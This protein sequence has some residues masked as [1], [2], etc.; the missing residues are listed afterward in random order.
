MAMDFDTL[1]VI[2]VGV[3][4]TAFVIVARAGNLSIQTK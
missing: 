4:V 3:V 1:M 2:L